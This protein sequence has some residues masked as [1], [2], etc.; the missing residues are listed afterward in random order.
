MAGF[1]GRSRRRCRSRRAGRGDRSSGQSAW[2]EWPRTDCGIPLPGGPARA[3]L[4]SWDTAI[5]GGVLCHSTLLLGHVVDLDVH[6]RSAAEERRAVQ[7]AERLD[8]DA[9]DLFGPQ[10]LA[11][12]DVI[13]HSFFIDQR[14]RPS[15]GSMMWISLTW[16]LRSSQIP[17]ARAWST[18]GLLKSSEVSGLQTT[19]T[20]LP[21]RP[22]H[23][24][25][26]RSLDRAGRSFPGRTCIRPP[27]AKAS[28]SDNTIAGH[29]SERERRSIVIPSSKTSIFAK[30]IARRSPGRPTPRCR[31]WSTRWA[32]RQPSSAEPPKSTT[33]EPDQAQACQERAAGVGR[34]GVSYFS[35]QQPSPR[36]CHAAGRARPL[37]NH[38]ERARRQTELLVRTVSPRIGRQ[39]AGRRQ[40][41]QQHQGQCPSAIRWPTGIDL[42]LGLLGS[43]TRSQ[44]IG[45]EDSDSQRPLQERFRHT[46]ECGNSFPLSILPCRA[47]Q[48]THRGRHRFLPRSSPA[49]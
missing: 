22:S 4:Q 43:F 1:S 47:G 24:A 16:A 31:P 39:G 42:R 8:V 13:F 7:N 48:G 34:Q 10:L 14:W 26:C 30:S 11:D 33:R 41:C 32:C 49:K 23:S 5:C 36:R 9:D 35:S 21:F 17:S 12:C 27:R 29:R 44:F 15:A 18:P 3:V 19:A 6:R 2:R 37:K 46:L 20:F 28:A 40:Q 38:I 25:G 45:G